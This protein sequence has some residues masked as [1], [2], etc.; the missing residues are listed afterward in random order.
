MSSREKQGVKGKFEDLVSWEDKSLPTIAKTTK[1]GLNKVFVKTPMLAKNVDQFDISGAYS[2]AMQFFQLPLSEPQSMGAHLTTAKELAFKLD[3]EDVQYGLFNISYKLP[4]GCSE[5]ERPL[6]IVSHADG[7]GFTGAETDRDQWFTMFE[8]LAL[9][10]IHE[11]LAIEV[12]VGYVW[13]KRRTTESLSLNALYTEFKSLRSKYKAL[14][15]KGSAMKNTVKLIANAGYAKTLQDKTVVDTGKL[16]AS[17]LRKRAADR[18]F[19]KTQVRSKVFLSIWGN[20]ITSSIRSVVAI[21]AWKNK[22]YMAVTDSIVC[23]TGT[24]VHSKDIKT[25]FSKFNRLLEQIHWVREYANVHMV[26]LKERYYYSFLLRDE[27]DT[28]SLVDLENNSATEATIDK[29]IIVKAAKRAFK[30]IY[31]DKDAQNI[32]FAK[33]SINRMGCPPGQPILFTEKSFT[34]FD[35]F[36]FN[37]KLLNATQYIT[38]KLGSDNQRYLCNTILNLKKEDA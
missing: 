20:A 37:G 29:L 14:G 2:A 27:K 10:T 1:G 35:D 38:K 5:W 11:N 30:S 16:F 8:V 6:T 19:F 4:D 22:A 13:L 25:P 17:V 34:K 32:D 31:T 15:E 9:A 3:T 28:Q 24:F 21:T 18:D 12:I 33:K 23:D 7:E 36:F 26:I